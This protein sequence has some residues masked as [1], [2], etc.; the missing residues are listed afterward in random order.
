MKFKPFKQN[1]S[2]KLRKLLEGN[3][4][5]EIDIRRPVTISISQRQIIQFLQHE[6]NPQM[7]YQWA[8]VLVDTWEGE[9]SE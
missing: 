7:I 1:E 6:T 2:T 5:C 3:V 4:T 8:R 9:L